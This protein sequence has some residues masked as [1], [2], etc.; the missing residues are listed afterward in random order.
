MN[1]SPNYFSVG[2]SIAPGGSSGSS[3]FARAS[4]PTSSGATPPRAAG[5]VANN[6][7]A[8]SFQDGTQSF[9]DLDISTPAARE[10]EEVA[11]APAEPEGPFQVTVTEPV[12][13]GEGMNAFIVYKVTTRTSLPQYS[14]AECSATRRFRDFDW[15]FAQLVDK[16]PGLI[17]PPLP[18]KAM[19][20]KVS[21]ADFTPEFI[22][23]RRRHLETFLRRVTSHPEQ[24]HAE[25]LQQF[26]ELGD[27]GLEAA[28]AA[29]RATSGQPGRWGQL[30]TDGW[31]GL[32]SWSGKKVGG[33]SGSA[34]PDGGIGDRQCDELRGYVARLE[35]QLGA[36]HKAA[37]RLAKRHR[38]ESTGMTEVGAAFAQLGANGDEDWPRLLASQL[39]HLGVTS[40]LAAR[41]LGEQADAEAEQ[42]DEPLRDLLRML[43]QCRHAL[44]TREHAYNVWQGAMVSLDTRRSKAAKALG[45]E[46]TD[47]KAA[48]MELEIG[49]CEAQ[50][51]QSQVEYELIK[52][53]FNRDIAR[54]QK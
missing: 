14:S 38:A 49:E 17:I 51:R 20:G 35:A 22:E 10:R 43:Q 5:G 47:G 30:L 3:P 7:M 34:L 15:L 48:Q 52:E 6:G 32:R 13:Q 40:D 44:N 50:V 2:S 28:K 45:A 53:R 29:S 54:F 27:D 42:L 21:G 9:Q 26:L 18:E 31:H 36:L 23:M 11:S 25:A 19:A 46:A 12:R 41:S 1:D 16:W 33:M 8:Q 4:Q 37:E 24:H 39:S